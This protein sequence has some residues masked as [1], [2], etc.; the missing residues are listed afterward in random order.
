MMAE[1]L[2]VGSVPICYERLLAYL[3]VEQ[4]RVRNGLTLFVIVFQFLKDCLFYKELL[5]LLYALHR[6]RLGLLVISF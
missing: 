5:L 3:K 6:H 4:N 1:E 2:F